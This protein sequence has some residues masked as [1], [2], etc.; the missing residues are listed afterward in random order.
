MKQSRPAFTLVELLVVI[1]IIGVLVGL[2]L[3]AVQA[4]RE[5]ARRMQC[6]N[7]LKQVALACHNYQ[8]TY[9]RFP[10]SS[11]VNLDVTTTGNNG[12]WGV[13]G[14][15]LPFLEQGN[16]FENVDLSLAWDDQQSISELKIPVFACPS[17]PGTDQVR[18][19]DDNRPSLYPTTYGFNFGRWFVFDPTTEKGGDGMFYPNKML[20]FRDCLDGSSHTLLIGE[21]KAWTPY[22]R[23]GGPSSITLPAT[24][25]DAEVIVAS[26]GQFKDTGHTEWPD[27]RVHHTGFTVTLAPNSVVRYTNSGREYE[28]MDYNSWQEGKDGGAGNPTYA[29]ITSRSHHTGLVQVAKV[30]GSVTSITESIDIETWHALGTRAGREVIQ[31]EW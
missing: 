6:S 26:G 12:S 19:F 31:G 7:H 10:P 25:L 5:A 30:D 15:I 9:G 23:N 20:D 1:A 16:V 8:S 21:V 14:R 2:L 29:M 24:Q 4:A 3:P 22:Q 11:L 13:H 27:G 18:T 28:E 17:D